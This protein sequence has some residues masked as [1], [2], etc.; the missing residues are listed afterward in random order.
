[1][2]KRL[3]TQREWTFLNWWLATHH[4]G[5]SIAMNV[6][7]G[8]TRPLLSY[9][10]PGAGGDGILRLPNRWADAVYVENHQLNLV[11][12]KIE[13]DPGIFS[14]LIHYARLL[15]IDPSYAQYRAAPIRMTALVYHDDPSLAEEAL[16]YGV[17]WEVHQPSLEGYPLPKLSGEA[18][19]AVGSELPHDFASRISWATGQ[20]WSGGR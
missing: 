15:R 16:W 11:E 8:P 12:A 14:Q 6:R 10:A 7:L 17:N 9:G 1:M 13:A 4:A 19:G 2:G 3:Y 5:A 18:L 20:S